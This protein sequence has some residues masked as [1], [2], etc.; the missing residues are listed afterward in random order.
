MRL[1]KYESFFLFM[2]QLIRTYAPIL[3]LFAGALSYMIDF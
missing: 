3:N 1:N 2:G